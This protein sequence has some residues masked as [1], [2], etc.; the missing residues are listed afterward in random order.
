MTQQQISM[1][2]AFPTFQQKTRELFEANM[3]LQA[4]ADVLEKRIAALQ[5]ENARLKEAAGQDGPP[6]G[7]PD[8]AATPPFPDTEEPQESAYDGP[9]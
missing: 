4:K 8:L 1:E 9:R 3:L 2:E 6:V 5:E 7:G